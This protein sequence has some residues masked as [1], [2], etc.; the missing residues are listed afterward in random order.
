LKKVS[1][2]RDKKEIEILKMYF[3]SKSIR[4]YLL[5]MI[6]INTNLRISDL[7]HLKVSDVKKGKRIKRVIDIT[8]GK[9]KKNKKIKINSNIEKALEEY[10]NETDLNE[11]D[12]LFPSKKNKMKPITRQQAHHILSQAGN[13]CGIE[14][15]I[16]P[17][18][19]RKTWGYH[20]WKMGISPALIMEALNHGSIQ[21]TKKYLG[22]LQDDLDEVYVSLNL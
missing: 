5:F 16:S 18:T 1:P 21:M 22:I 10:F 4:D 11:C 19:L 7:L 8:E 14:D 15:S 20:A 9:T 17:H 2:I 3:E 13:Y 12:Y 6:G